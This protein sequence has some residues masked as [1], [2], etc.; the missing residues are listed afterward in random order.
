MSIDVTQQPCGNHDAV[1]GS[2]IGWQPWC[3]ACNPALHREE[4]PARASRCATCREFGVRVS[5]DGRL[6]YLWGEEQR[7]QPLSA[8]M[9]ATFAREILERQGAVPPA[10]VDAVIAGAA[11]A[12]TELVASPPGDGDA[13]ELANLIAF[14]R[15]VAGEASTSY[16]ATMT[17]LAD[18]CELLLAERKRLTR[19]LA[20]LRAAY[21]VSERQRLQGEMEA[22]RLLE[23]LDAA[24]ARAV[25]TEAPE[26]ISADV[27]PGEYEAAGVAVA[28][29][30]E[31]RLAAVVAEVMALDVSEEDIDPDGDDYAL[32]L[33]QRINAWMD[34]DDET[35][36]GRRAALLECAALSIAGILACDAAAKQKGG[37]HVPSCFMKGDSLDGD[38]VCECNGDDATSDDACTCVTTPGATVKSGEH[39]ICVNCGAEVYD[40]AECATKGGA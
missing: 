2:A 9:S 36:A 16:P 35:I 3:P 40:H 24:R 5:P 11:Q 6:T 26:P 33:V 31:P 22:H 7:E 19:N 20:H 25:A 21:E 37:A 23:E 12:P 10:A 39:P 32:R 29:M 27:L 14:A 30:H 1:T 34:S 28:M 4:A 8:E 17:E 13:R 18:A 38:D 15:E